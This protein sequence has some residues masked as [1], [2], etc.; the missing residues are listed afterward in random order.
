MAPI[1]SGE[2]MWRRSGMGLRGGSSKEALY[3]QTK[4][5]NIVVARQFANRYADK[6]IISF[7][8]NPGNIKTELQRYVPSLQRK[9]LVRRLIT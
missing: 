6:G 2:R 9:I 7:S 3:Y 4:H 8:L 5:T 1:C